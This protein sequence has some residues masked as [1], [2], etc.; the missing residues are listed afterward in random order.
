MKLCI[1]TGIILLLTGAA[2]PDDLSA[3][4]ADCYWEGA[5]TGY[6]HYCPVAGAPQRYQYYGCDHNDWHS[7]DC[8]NHPR[9]EPFAAAQE[10]LLNLM[11]PEE[12]DVDFARLAELALAY[13]NAI[14][15]VKAERTIQIFDCDGELYAER[16]FTEDGIARF[17]R[18]ALTSTE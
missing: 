6:V 5:G 3:Q 4:C 9:C 2:Q 13:P 11:V 12:E 15:F 16:R 17:R 1:T 14:K 18:S 10:G 7:G 8:S